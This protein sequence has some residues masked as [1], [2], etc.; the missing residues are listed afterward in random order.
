MK[1]QDGHAYTKMLKTII[2]LLVIINVAV[3]AIKFSNAQKESDQ[4]KTY[5]TG[6]ILKPNHSANLVDY[7][8]EK[9]NIVISP[10]NINTSINKLYNM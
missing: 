6:D 8:Y 7:A 2:I 9:Q 4:T 1:K 5:Y 3:I 10:I